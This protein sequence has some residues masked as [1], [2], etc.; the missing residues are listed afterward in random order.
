VCVHTDNFATKIYRQIVGWEGWGL[1]VQKTLYV[2]VADGTTVED[3]TAY[4]D[5]LAE[6]MSNV[7]VIESFVGPFRPHIQCGDEAEIINEEGKARLIG[8]ITNVKHNFGK[9]GF[10]TEFTVDSGGQLGKG[11]ISDFIEKINQKRSVSNATR[12][13]S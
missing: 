6:R 12:L 10:S 4:A 5:E 1:G 7:G 11:R 9:S 2:A 8:L 13:Y 3:C